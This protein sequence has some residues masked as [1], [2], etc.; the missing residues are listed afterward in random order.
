MKFLFYCKDREGNTKI[1]P[2]GAEVTAE[3]KFEKRRGRRTYYEWHLPRDAEVYVLGS[4]VID[5][6]EGDK[7]AVSDGKDKFPFIISDESETEVMLRQGRKG[8]LGLGIAQNATIFLGLILFGAV[9]SFAATDFLLAAM[10]APL[11]LSFS[12][13]VLMYNDLIFLRNRVKRA[14]ANIEVSPKEKKRF[15]PQS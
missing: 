2:D 15:D 7:L 10:F 12:M 14:W 8:L 6:V 13:F 4:A 9:G 5:E 1:I 3:L 11:F